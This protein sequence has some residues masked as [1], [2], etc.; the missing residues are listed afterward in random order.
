MKTVTVVMAFAFACLVALTV[1]F[2]VTGCGTKAPPVDPETGRR[3]FDYATKLEAC[4]SAK[5]AGQLVRQVTFETCVKREG[6]DQ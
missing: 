4:D 5:D 2:I 1:A 6:L 3:L